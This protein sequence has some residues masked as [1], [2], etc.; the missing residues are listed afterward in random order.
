MVRVSRG[1]LVAIPTGGLETFVRETKK[2]QITYSIVLTIHLDHLGQQSL[3]L[4]AGG[5]SR[6]EIL[7]DG[8][9]WADSS[10]QVVSF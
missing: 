4:R 6:G 8:T 10:G 5:T 7:K 2:K 9:E 3:T 1:L